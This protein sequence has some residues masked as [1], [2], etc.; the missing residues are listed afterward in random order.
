MGF[1]SSIGKAL[2]APFKLVTAPLQAI[3]GLLGGGSGGGSTST[4]TSSRT[5]VNPVTNVTNK[6]DLEPLA[7]ILAKSNEKNSKLTAQALGQSATVSKQAATISLINSERDRQLEAQKL[8]KVDTY[9]EHAKNGLV[10]SAV[11]ASLI[12]VYKKGK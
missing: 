7:D 8:K 9:L 11:A 10:I 3:G 4:V 2:S 1:F 12:Y 6:I 5:T